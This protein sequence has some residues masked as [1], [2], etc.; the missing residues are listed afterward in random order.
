MEDN[1]FDNITGNETDAPKKGADNNT[2]KAEKAAAPS[3]AFESECH[4]QEESAANGDYADTEPTEKSGCCEAGTENSVS[5]EPET[6]TDSAGSVLNGEAYYPVAPSENPVLNQENPA[7]N[8]LNPFEITDGAYD[9]ISANDA[10]VSP[11][12]KKKSPALIILTAVILTAALIFGAYIVYNSHFS[13]RAR[14]FSALSDVADRY[15]SLAGDAGEA[16]E[17]VSGL[18]N[19]GFVSINGSVTGENGNESG[20][21]TLFDI[22]YSGSA[23]SADFRTNESPLLSFYLD[24][25]DMTLGI[26]GNTPYSLDIAT[27]EDYHGE[28]VDLIESYKKLFS[29]DEDRS[30]ASNQLAKILRDTVTDE[31]F[32][33]CSVTVDGETY[34]GIRFD[35]SGNNAVKIGLSFLEE[36]QASDNE[37]LKKQIADFLVSY[38]GI[39]EGEDSEET[40]ENGMT[41]IKSAEISFIVDVAVKDSKTA[42]L[43]VDL[44]DGDTSANLIYKFIKN[45][46]NAEAKTDFSVSYTDDYGYESAYSFYAEGTRTYSDEESYTA[47]GAAKFTK[48]TDGEE[49]V[50]DGEYSF[51]AQDEAL[52][53]ARIA[54]ISDDENDQFELTFSWSDTASFS[55]TSMTGGYG[56]SYVITADKSY[57]DDTFT[58]SGGKLIISEIASDELLNMYSLTSED[59]GVSSVSFDFT[60]KSQK[61]YY[62]ASI[63]YE[64]EETSFSADI[65][66]ENKG[67]VI[68]RLFADSILNAKEIEAS[69]QVTVVTDGNE[70]RWNFSAEID[71]A[72]RPVITA[73]E[74]KTVINGEDTAID[75]DK[76][77]EFAEELSVLREQYALIDTAWTAYGAPLI[78]ELSNGEIDTADYNSVEFDF[79]DYSSV[80]V[81]ETRVNQLSAIF[82]DDPVKNSVNGY[83]YLYYYS[84]DYDAPNYTGV[85]AEFVDGGDG[86]IIYKAYIDYNSYIVDELEDTRYSTL[87]KGMSAE[88]MLL[89]MGEKQPVLHEALYQDGNITEAY[90]YGIDSDF[91]IK[92]TVTL[93]DGEITDI[94]TSDE[95]SE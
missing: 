49:T 35:A 65:S 73:L 21:E 51:A 30:S 13:Q 92:L 25:T 90:Y 83:D 8:E 17:S 31:Y 6:N 80:S 58:L 44:S 78:S 18:E 46:K 72:S 14:F 86:T 7:V 45:G 79:A 93:I 89:I 68:S 12:K 60:Q 16:L 40:V 74:N 59:L 87:R 77:A 3:N 11:A 43:T 2:Q 95:V 5:K 85:M 70:S 63:S 1:I 23:A 84:P 56:T 33:D 47:Q 37:Q 4:K 22:K 20:A 62:S 94:V 50:M 66:L 52:T 69:G 27:L 34:D 41:Y 26:N 67:N 53:G 15:I 88:A 32:T 75:S 64:T 28:S 36:V 71:F 76:Y 61:N 9:G 57:E 42:V 81:G 91:Q 10:S 82:S 29:S 54:L 48:K 19:A 39:R 38:L 24:D 55:Y